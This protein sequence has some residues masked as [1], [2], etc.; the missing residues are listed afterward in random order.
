[1]DGLS[2]KE[3]KFLSR[4]VEHQIEVAAREIY[5]VRCDKVGMYDPHHLQFLIEK[6]QDH[7]GKEYY[8]RP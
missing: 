1:M 6:C 3:K 4:H 7:I 2:E 8:R 5:H